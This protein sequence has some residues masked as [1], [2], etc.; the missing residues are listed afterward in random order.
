M[1]RERERERRKG[2]REKRRGDVDDS[3]KW[4]R[5]GFDL[6]ASVRIT[7]KYFPN[8]ITGLPFEINDAC[9]ALDGSCSD[10]D[11]ERERGVVAICVDRGITFEST[12]FGK[13]VRAT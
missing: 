9:S 7:N 3:R 5:D 4:T 2:K 6:T 1:T 11:A 8:S 13:R 10:G 12:R